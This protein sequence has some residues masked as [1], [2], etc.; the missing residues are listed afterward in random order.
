MNEQQDKGNII[1]Y[2]TPDGQSKIEVTL[3]GDTVHHL[4]AHKKR[5]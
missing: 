2:Q 4:T 1:L 3:S 5:V